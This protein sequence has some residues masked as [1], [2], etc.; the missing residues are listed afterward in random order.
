VSGQD[1]LIVRGEGGRE[2]LRA[3]LEKRG[4]RVRYAEVYA[5]RRPGT[6]ELNGVWRASPPDIIVTTSNEGLENLV[7][8]TDAGRREMLFST[9]LV[10][11]S[12]RARARAAELGFRGRVATAASADD[13]VLF[14]CL[15]S[16]VEKTRGR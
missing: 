14:E 10:V 9:P 1:V 6:A 4:A 3:E 5:R 2:A 13:S 12:G 7:E 16:L 8:M 15:V 11:T